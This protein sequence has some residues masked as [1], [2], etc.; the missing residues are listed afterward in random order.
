MIA[1]PKIATP[2]TLASVS[3][4]AET[5]SLGQ[6]IQA[7]VALSK[8]TPREVLLKQGQKLAFSLSS[9]LRGLA[10][11]K[12]SIRE[13]RLALLASGVGLHVR[14]AAIEYARKHT[15]A[16]ASNLATRREALFME[17]TRRGN[18]KKNGRSFWQIAIDRELS[19][20]E[21]GRG[22]LGLA[23]RINNIEKRLGVGAEAEKLDRVRRVIGTVGITTALDTDTL[24]FRFQRASIVEGMSR[25]AARTNIAAAI[26]DVRADILA[27]VNRKLAE[28]AK[29]SRLN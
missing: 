17:K 29:K 24:T 26:A 9:R 4:K 14:P 18:L 2:P 3:L 16:T 12:G 6:A 19:I 11:A 7:Y 1:P 20:R 22:Y 23:P 25:A 21:S 15:M 10:P 5:E 13:Q 8:K 28:N 27:Y